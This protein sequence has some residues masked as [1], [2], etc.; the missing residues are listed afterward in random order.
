M[1]FKKVQLIHIN[2]IFVHWIQQIKKP[3]LCFVLF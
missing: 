3:R 1:N 2:V